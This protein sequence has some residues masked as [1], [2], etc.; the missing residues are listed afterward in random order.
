M[1]SVWNNAFILPTMFTVH[2]DPGWHGAGMFTQLNTSLF[3]SLSPRGTMNSA[4]LQ[5][6]F[7]TVEHMGMSLPIWYL[8]WWNFLLSYSL[9][10]FS[11]AHKMLCV[12]GC[13]ESKYLYCLG[14]PYTSQ[15]FAQRS[16]WNESKGPN[17]F[18]IND[19]SNIF[20]IYF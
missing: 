18:N 12:L 20:I 2:P 1:S 11:T 10:N 14:F 6:I 13:G 9:C 19:F 17:K 8:T 7:N 3:S 5:I 16:L 15:W 4:F